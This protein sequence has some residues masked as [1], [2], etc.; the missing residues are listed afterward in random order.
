MIK[1]IKRNLLVSLWAM[2]FLLPFGG[3]R[4][5]VLAFLAAFAAMSLRGPAFGMLGGVFS[6]IRPMIPAE[7]PEGLKLPAGAVF[8]IFVLSFPFFSGSYFL[9]VS[10]LAG[11][12]I[13]LSLGLNVVVG[14]T[15]LL[16]LGFA[17]FYAVGA[18]SY[19][20]LNTKMGVGFW[21]AVPIASS[22]AALSGFLLAVPAIRLRGDYY[23][24][25]TLGFGEI[26]RLVLNNWDS[27]T[28]GPNGIGGISPPHLMDKPLEDL[29]S[30]YYVV[31]AFAALSAFVIKR[32]HASPVGRAWEAVREDET[33]ASA[34]GVNTAKYKLLSSSFGAFWAG[35]AGVL[36]A[37]KM[38]FVSPESF[39]F[40]ESVIILCMVIL[41]GMGSIR[42]AVLGAL[43][44]VILPEAL[45]GAEMLRMLVLGAGMVVLMIFRP[46]GILGRKGV[47]LRA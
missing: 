34:M 19:A 15:G 24:I 20:L 7:A 47:S 30:Y 10:I 4:A 28:N 6:K 43:I 18:Y 29:R 22:F 14:Y 21:A 38:R 13:I 3:L 31:L 27:L 16:N 26:I 42:G 8:L 39:T 25:V 11:I 45:R 32:V 12:Y 41:G 17:A 37:A 36:F 44:L 5:G 35:L 9:D 40:M 2:L 33:A 23:A 1:G 46:Q